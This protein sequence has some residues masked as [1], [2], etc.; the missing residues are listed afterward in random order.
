MKKHRA[1]WHELRDNRSH[2]KL[3]RFL[4]TRFKS[5]LRLLIPAFLVALHRGHQQS[6]LLHLCIAD[7]GQHP[8][9]RRF[10]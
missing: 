1:Q 5:L 10:Q 6:N 4:S 7:T 3:L 9:A 2:K 8:F